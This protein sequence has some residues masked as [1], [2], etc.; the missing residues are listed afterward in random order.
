MP[1]YTVQA[2]DGKIYKLEG[3]PNA[4]QA[5][6]AAAIERQNPYATKTTEQLKAEPGAATSVGDIGRSLG[7]GLV[8][9][10]KSIA[11]VFGAGSDVSNYLGETMQGLQS[12]LTPERQAEMARRS[13]LIERADKSGSMFEQAK[14]YL[15][16]V[17]EAPLQTTVQALGTSA[18]AILAGLATLPV[19]APAGIAAGVGIISRLAI[20][21][22]QGV[23]E[24]KGSAYD[25]VKAHYMKEGKGEVEASRLAEEAQQYS[26]DKALQYGGAALL[27][28]LDA[29]LGS[30]NVAMKAMRRVAPTGA[31]TKEAIDA[32][33]KALPAKPLTKPSLGRAFGESVLG[34]APLEGAQ[35]A[36]GQY[37]QNVAMQQA[38]IDTPTEQ[39]VFGSGLRD[40]LVG[41]LAGGVFT[42]LHKS[43]MNSAYN[44]DQFLRQAQGEQEIAG[45][46]QAAL[47]RKQ[48]KDQQNLKMRSLV[49][50]EPSTMLAL[51]AP[52]AKAERE[53]EPALIDLQNPVGRITRNELPAETISYIDSY[54]AE[55]NL[56]RLTSFSLEDV[57]DAMTSQ[58]P[59]GERAALDSIIA[60]KTGYTGKEKYSPED[61]LNAAVEKN[62]APETKGFA[63]FLQR[64]T[65]ERDVNT[66]SQPQLYSAFNALKAT[67]PSTTGE[68]IVLPEGSNATRF[69]TDQYNEGLTLLG[70]YLE[71]GQGKPLSMQQATEV[72]SAQT[73]LGD[74][75]ADILRVA[76]NND[77]VIVENG[78]VFQTV[79][80][81]TGEVTGS[82]G[83]K[84]DAQKAAGKTATVQEGRGPVV[85]NRVEEKQVKRAKLPG[86][87]ELE[88]ETLKEG[89][90]PAEYQIMVE[91]KAKPLA[92]VLEENDVAGKVERLQGLRQKEAEKVLTDI[93]KH[94]KT[95]ASGRAKLESMEA[96]GQV[97][98][99]GFKKAQAQQA[100]AEDILG[101]R[102]QRML[103]QIEEFSA[104]LKAKPA[105]KKQ[106]TRTAFKLTKEGKEV[107]KF[108]SRAAAEESVLSQLTDAELEAIST[109][110][111]PTANRA[112][113]ALEARK[114]QKAGKTG[115]K[116]KGT[117]AGLEAA[118]VYTQETQAKIV[119]LR[120]QLLPMLAKFGLGD[121]GLKIVRTLEAGAEGS[122][123]DKLIQVTLTADQPITTM[124]HEAL[125]ALK[126]MG[127]FTPAQWNVL[128]KKANEEWI[129]KYLKGVNAE[130]NGK[131][132]S[133]YD[134]Y[135]YI[136]QTLPEQWNRANPNKAP[137]DVMSDVDMQELLIEEAIADAFGAFELGADKPTPGMIAAL[138]KRLQDFFTAFAEALGRAK[139]ESAEEI[140]GKI[141]KGELAKAGLD[142]TAREKLSLAGMGVPRSTRSIMESASK[143]AQA[144]L[145]LNTE[146]AKGKS[147]VNNVRDVGKQLNRYTL[148]QFGGI[149]RDDPTAKDVAALASA[150]ADEVGYQLRVNA[151]T[152]TGTGWY[153]NNYPNALKKLGK[154]FPELETN[155]LARSVFSAIVAVTSNGEDVSSNIKSA[156]RYYQDFRN[157]KPLV[158][159]GS[160]RPTALENNLSQIEKLFEKHGEN[161][162]Q[163]LT[164]EITVAELN[165]YLR[166][167]GEKPSSDYLKETKIPAAAIYFGPK[168][169]AFFAN[170]SGSEGYLTMDL[171]WTRSINRMRGL[172][173][174]SATESSIISFR[175]L[176]DR[177]S[178]TR[179]EVIA[180]AV[181]FK[182]K[183]EEHGYTTELEFLAGEKEPTTNAGHPKWLAK[184]KRKAGPSFQQLMLEHKLEK[185]ANTIYK[186]EF[187]MLKEDPFNASDRKFMYDVA[188]SAQKLLKAEGI[189]LSLADIQAAL[190]YYEKR[191]Y[192]KLTGREADDIGYEEAIIARASDNDRREGPSVVFSQQS[193]RRDAARGK[194]AAP[195]ELGGLDGGKLSLKKGVVAEVAPNPDHI[196]A[197]KWREMTTQER[198]DSTKAVANKIMS[199]VF[200]E[201]GLTGY[202]YTF[203]SGTY[204]GEANP[205]II[206]EA[207]DSATEQELAELGKVLGY[208]LDQKAMVVFDENNKTSGD[209]A[210]FVKVR[211]PEG[212]SQEELSGLRSHIAR[213]V[214]QADGDTLRNGALLYGNFSAYND[215]V[216]TV[217]DAQYHQA[218][219]DAVES[220]E[221]DGVIDVSSPETFHSAFIWPDTRADYLKET[222]YGD[223]KGLQGE[224][225]A[226]VRGQGSRRLQAISEDAIALRDRWIDARGAAR[227]GGRERG[228]AV[229]Y[230]NPTA[231]YGIPQK[232][233][234]SVIGVH[235]SQQPRD[236]LYSEYYGTGL[237]GFEQQ[238]LSDKENADI[239]NRIY[240]Y[241]DNGAGVR[242][243]SGVGGSP[244]VIKLNNLYDTKADPLGFIKN[245]KGADAAER[246][247]KWERSIK[248]AGFDGYLIKDQ[249]ASQDYATLIGKHAVKT[250]L[251]LGK[252]S[253][254]TADEAENAAYGKAPPQTREFKL[255]YG[256]STLID[257]G[258]PQVM[259]HG[260][261]T[262]ISTFYEDKPIFVTPD[263][264]FA[265]DFAS[266]RAKDN[267]KD[268]SAVRIYPLWVR[269]ETP[270]DY[271]NSDH[272][273][274]IMQ[275][276]IADQNATKPDST[277]R[278]RKST[279]VPVDKLRSEI[280][281][282]LWSVIEDKTVQ[283]I[284]KSLG[285]DSFTVYESNKKNLAV[286]SAAQV[287][288]VTGNIGEFGREAKDIRFSLRSFKADELPQKSKSYTLPANTLLYHGAHET[289][290]KEIEIAGKVL[291]SR[292]PIKTSG[293]TL[294][295]GG[296]VF[297]GDKDA[298]TGYAN[299]ENDPISVQAAKERGENRKPG[300]VFETATDRP[301]RLMNKNYKLTKKEAE[302]L[303]KVLG[304]PDYKLLK[305]GDSASTAA[306][307]AVTNSRTVDSY[308]TN[309]GEMVVV[310]PMIFNQ[311]GYD[312]YFDDFAVALA[313]DN[314]IRLVGKD[315]RLEKFSLPAVSKAADD[316]V[317]A[318]TTTREVKGF[319]ERITEAISP[320]A[321]SYFRAK[322]LH[323]YNQLGVYDRIVAK[324]MGGIAFL[325]DKSAEA[326]AL[327]SDLGAGVTASALG[328][329]DRHGGIPA[330][331]NG[332]TT[333][334]RSVK[335]LVASLAPLA[336][337]NNPKVY[338]Y[339]QYWSAV[340]RGTRLLEAGKERLINEGD[341]ALAAELE[342]KFP[343]FIDVQKDYTAFNNGVVKY[344]VDTG[345]LSKERGDEYMKY[346]DYI[347]F[348]RQVDGEKTIGP[349][350]FQAIAGV[351]PP[352]KLTG[353]DA[354]L[355]DFLETIVRNT[356]A[357][358]QAGMKNSAAQRAINVASQVTEPGMGVER[359]NTK[360]SGPDI[361]NVLEKGEQ[362]SYRTPDSLLI[363][364]IGSLH[365]PD[366]PFLSILSAPS[367][368][369][370]N[371]V[372]KDPGFMLANLMR[373]SLSAWVTSG[374][375]MTPI[376]GTVINFGK[377]LA[378]KSPSMQALMDAGII[379]G[380]EFSANV[381]SSGAKLAQDLTR[382]SGKEGLAAPL[383]AVRWLWEGL[384][385]GTT[386]SDAATRTLVYERVM[387]ETG[388]EAE[389]LYRAMEVMNFNRKGSS[390]V[391]RVLTAAVPFFN[392]RL[393]GLDLLYRAASGQ[394][395]MDNA[396]GIQK[397][398]FV[399]GAMMM[400]LTAIYWFLTHDDEEYK[401]Q[402]QETRDN[403]WLFPR[404]GIKMPTPFEVGTIFKTIPERIL[405][406]TFGNDTGKD[407]AESMGRSML[408]TFAFN[409]T[410][411]AI[412]PIVEVV[413][414]FNF[415]T[416]RPIIGQG[417]EDVASQYQVGPGTSKAFEAF[418]KMTGLSPMKVEHLYKGYTGTMGM[419]LVDVVD[420]ILNANSNSPNATKRFEQL[421]VVKRFALDPEARGNITQYYELKNAV[422]TTVRTMNLLEKTARPAEFSAYLQD[423]IG[424][425]SNKDY[426]RNLEKS[427]K[428]LREMRTAIRSS[429]MT[430]DEK[431]DSLK[432]VGQMENNLTSNIQ[433][434]KKSIASMK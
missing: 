112:A 382:K 315:G 351:K 260:S 292:S 291:I 31:M 344:M 222:R 350:I 12:G 306:Y 250:K 293:G 343:E 205:N 118:G 100:K 224:A 335:G 368:L 52:A 237:R 181:P 213:E 65:G 148:D 203:S 186:N 5:D 89:E 430:G 101:R 202:T 204:E 403:N 7:S 319:G 419:Y 286:Y 145:G 162:T 125:H 303:N 25:A 232:N 271:E 302:G 98:T 111:G 72:V 216:D 179:E 37:S 8:G 185:M 135:I 353:S 20:G 39:G 86:G 321:W 164:K 189:D 80:K 336:K 317:D 242:A 14:A 10:V 143:F 6:L 209:Q 311:L 163:E 153:S 281:R 400:G 413:T 171:W 69:T 274:Q 120:K 313:A 259:Y 150:V 307:R 383:R 138:F 109:Q 146:K 29:V 53:I 2:A 414:N 184:A 66:M 434:V 326:A 26:A 304:I 359:L 115:I 301:Y 309:K 16:G 257:E 235:F 70:K 55:N 247:N 196:S 116:V 91:G 347:P 397:T 320:K 3:P 133:R 279:N 373:D 300:V 97:D 331:R 174:P 427:M 412:K 198:L 32:G 77:D 349:N 269:A 85:R 96:R 127:F 404:A 74:Y 103:D 192:A 94:E 121:V 407:F 102:I 226:D 49:E 233:S 139:I 409:P 316:R 220:F 361:I 354:P 151:K 246:F 379:G 60:A 38:G 141:E 134:A 107:G 82:Y 128:M 422:D 142:Q 341:I 330:Y 406:Y 228:N 62:I 35:G 223:S 114:D 248:E 284:I 215:K 67:K 415:F 160:R 346:A 332:V 28:S 187:D 277:L 78:P 176:M 208:V 34:E 212:M 199:R 352:K 433:T 47:K 310:W 384:E 308:Q 191:L 76:A 188:R 126:D 245:T 283:D 117:T 182:Q 244:H 312:G 158:A 256:A 71:Q 93:G 131:V 170:L 356:Q 398:F 129:G 92:S 345:V 45:E 154:V 265:E 408:S 380:Y 243:E 175:D 325:A 372:T 173:I 75:A 152:G 44:I 18:P 54:R 15:G 377:A 376:A 83:A 123:L 338:Q 17:T 36:F 251:S 417:M 288:S 392:A 424:I 24:F 218:I 201:L 240:F 165:A 217:S 294:D 157:G 358:I 200:S 194:G 68:Q 33:I 322:A 381:E 99:E 423:N 9:G 371:L 230:G 378:N 58:N 289:R 211:I 144:E 50:G 410:P 305:E 327:F 360:Q 339:Y 149:T 298:A 342:K 296:L 57:K 270:F 365:M 63:D 234:V 393:Q 278:L 210:G 105:G 27:G 95:V 375:S 87:Y 124:R 51:P 231:E 22:A 249:T 110:E 41:S 275:R 227:L 264:G 348:Y 357:S 193:N 225:G 46:A 391:I 61:I 147:G 388:N 395:N 355:A 172:L 254:S 425:L 219:R 385:K 263:V 43:T 236:T 401:K 367:D 366:I 207:P 318:T 333:I 229:D 40:A 23:G 180:A 197:T 238:R 314:G 79:D 206:V 364:A 324:T 42:P 140:F 241:V 106:V 272:V 166:S 287:K 183:Y 214:P 389:A 390:P 21:A 374:Q 190:W 1:I 73:D 81:E 64:A 137:R 431:R 411:Q 402:E 177:P 239:R 337:Y 428:E 195:D 159:T 48:E 387:A 386:A 90:K 178:A 299:S 155:P 267:D 104:P 329:G 4:S 432:Y 258:R 334:D 119:E 108:P 362:V 276:L 370:R 418:G 59:A 426:V 394:M 421:P 285:F 130:F 11:D 19:S 282:G 297:F 88:E 268:P 132:M 280:K 266:D 253:F 122:Y 169:G 262:D 429:G 405:E 295:E 113:K 323:R 13:E 340:K 56:P 221:Y 156:I 416:M 290:A 84:E 136:N 30:E 161:F 261:D 328:Y 273:E 396:K 255:F 363:D 369:L 252:V 399:N 167:V 420:S 168:L